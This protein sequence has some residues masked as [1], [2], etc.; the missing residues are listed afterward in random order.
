[1]AR[2][3]ALALA[4]V[5]VATVGGAA[6]GEPQP[7]RRVVSLSPALTEILFALDLGERVVGVTRYCDYPAEATTRPQVGGYLDPS[8]EAI[9][10][11]R[12]DLVL[13][14]VE[15][16]EVRPRLEALGLETLEADLRRVAAVPEAVEAVARRCGV[17]ERG[18]SLAREIRGRLEAVAERTGGLPRPRVLV[19]V[20]RDL[21]TGT[22]NR[23]W[24][25]GPGS[26]YHDVL[27]LAGG[28]NVIA[29]GRL[30]YPEVSR[31][32]LVH[33]DPDVILD[34]VAEPELRGADRPTARADWDALREL[35]AVRAGRV[36]LLDQELMVIPGPRI[37]A[38]VEAVAD[39]LHP[40][41]GSPP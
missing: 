34:V 28:K 17:A 6:A 9:V 30:P 16:G 8:Y 3:R 23:L 27:E 33:L 40:G 2:A 38:L 41:A 25:A 24:A 11:L 31:E 37:A 20:E 18:A 10:A 5:L 15:H 21:G 39:A 22:V 14:Q 1:M 36:V 12:P 29:D 7:P 4:L 13:L 35:R 26:F 32:G 19:A